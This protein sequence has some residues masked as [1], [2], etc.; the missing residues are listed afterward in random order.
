MPIDEKQTLTLGDRWRNWL[1]KKRKPAEDQKVEN[2]K[3]NELQQE[4][5]PKPT[6]TEPDETKNGVD[7]EE[8]LDQSV[9]Q[10]DNPQATQEDDMEEDLALLDEEDDLW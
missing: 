2:V 4:N 6:Q 10:P 9:Y 8:N 3:D 7:E 5:H 1:K